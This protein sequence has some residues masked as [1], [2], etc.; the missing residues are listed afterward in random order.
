MRALTHAIV[1]ASLLLP[2]ACS[3]RG[4]ETPAHAEGE[5]M[6]VV[7]PHERT[8]NADADAPL[9]AMSDYLAGLEHF[10][11]RTEGNI[12]MVLADGQKLAFP[13][14]SKVWVHRPAGLRTD[15]ITKDDQ[16][17]FF[18]DGHTFTLYGK[19][20]GFY[21]QLAAPD[22]LD[23]AIVAMSQ[24]LDLDAPG[25]DLLAD[26]AYAAL[27][28]DVI[29]GFRVGSETIDGAPCHHLAF[30]GNEVDWQIWIEEGARPLPRRF[31]ITSK[32]VQ[33]SPQFAVYLSEWN[34]RTKLPEKVFAFEPPA[35]A[36][37]IEFLTA[38]AAAPKQFVSQ[39]PSG[40]T[41]VSGPLYNCAGTMYRPYYHNLEVVFVQQSTETRRA[42]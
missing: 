22:T 32:K 30:R 42:P 3:L 10:T 7:E 2:T 20:A 41:L 14:D 13:Y 38:G 28:E 17:Q 9:H 36:Q 1:L 29:S 5:T 6:K 39:L 23:K 35:G 15:R 26:D 31:L 34:M 8:I 33:G 11:V 40:C 21:A 4:K 24:Q 37:K 19:R 18:Y 25:A 12:E 16:L 27:T